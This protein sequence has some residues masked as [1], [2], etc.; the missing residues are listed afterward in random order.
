[1]EHGAK[2]GALVRLR[3]QIEGDHSGLYP[4]WRLAALPTEFAE[5]RA[6]TAGSNAR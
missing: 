5:G 3:P 2:A 6:F 1:M 4:P